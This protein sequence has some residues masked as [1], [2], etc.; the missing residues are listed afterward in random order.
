[1]KNKQT[2]AACACAVFVLMF[3]IYLHFYHLKNAPPCIS[4]PLES[5]FYPYHM[6]VAFVTTVIFFVVVL[7]LRHFLRMTDVDQATDKQRKGVIQNADIISL[8]ALIVSIVVTG[9]LPFLQSPLLDY[10]ATT[11]NSTRTGQEHTNSTKSLSITQQQPYPNIIMP[12]VYIQSHQQHNNTQ[13]YNATIKISNDGLV[14]AKNVIIS[15]GADDYTFTRFKSTPFL[16][17]HLNDNDYKKGFVQIDNLPPRSE[18]ILTT[19]YTTTSKTPIKIVPYVRSDAWVGYHDTI[20]TVI[21]YS[22]LGTS[23]VGL[24]IYMEFGKKIIPTKRPFW[25]K[26]SKNWKLLKD[27]TILDIAKF[28]IGFAVYV[29]LFTILYFIHILA[30]S[31]FCNNL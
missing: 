2:V 15:I 14:A 19:N 1:M 13:T 23:Y 7:S 9:I 5:F 21:F 29:G 26:Y 16:S 12:Y 27:R 20:P 17:S 4:Y 30:P 22:I 28:L 6:V 24:F 10:T 8:G 3:G 25:E 31:S 18:T 11:L